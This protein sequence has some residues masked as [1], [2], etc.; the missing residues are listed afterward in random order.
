VFR[1]QAPIRVN[2]RNYEDGW[3]QS[4]AVSQHQAGSEMALSLM[5]VKIQK[6]IDFIQILNISE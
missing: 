4:I 5:L 1:L 3:F 6:H 2:N